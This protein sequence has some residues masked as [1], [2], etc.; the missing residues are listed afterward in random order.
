MA[1]SHI[2]IE[3]LEVQQSK[4]MKVLAEIGYDLSKID[5]LGQWDA[6][7]F[8]HDFEIV[9]ARFQNMCN[10]I[11]D[12]NDY[13]PCIELVILAKD[14][15]CGKTAVMRIPAPKISSRFPS[16]V[17]DLLGAKVTGACALATRKYDSKVHNVCRFVRIT[18]KDGK[19]LT[20]IVDAECMS[21]DRQQFKTGEPA[22]KYA[23][24]FI[25]LLS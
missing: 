14:P 7:E 2:D 6:L 23:S 19:K 18:L 15:E 21:S 10:L 20:P 1:T 3:Q 12:G 11:I 8:D 9:G 17:D 16:D 24:D 25:D 4:A 5:R 22:P 13:K